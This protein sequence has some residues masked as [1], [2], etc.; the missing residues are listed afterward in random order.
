MT[1]HQH[2]THLATGGLAKTN[3]TTILAND[4]QIINHFEPQEDGFLPSIKR[5][6]ALVIRPLKPLK[7]LKKTPLKPLEKK[8]LRPLKPLK[9]PEQK[10]NWRGYNA[11]SLKNWQ[12]AAPD[13][14]GFVLP[15]NIGAMRSHLRSCTRTSLGVLASGNAPADQFGES[16]PTLTGGFQSQK[17]EANMAKSISCVTAQNS[18]VQSSSATAQPFKKINLFFEASAFGMARVIFEDLDFTQADLQANRK[19]I[20]KAFKQ[21]C[22]SGRGILDKD[23][24]KPQHA[25]ISY[26]AGH[27]IIKQWEVGFTLDVV[28]CTD[29]VIDSKA[30]AIM[31]RIAVELHEYH[32]QTEGGAL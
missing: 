8:P 27:T 28:Q 20:I 25:P 23:L 21:A 18:A 6:C 17:L 11:I 16:T 32:A 4:K 22:L 26:Y 7:P 24:Y 10:A 1:I 5:A 12:Y 9:K 19:R 14:G 15:S 2:K 29:A 31:Q 3:G 30:D 13:N